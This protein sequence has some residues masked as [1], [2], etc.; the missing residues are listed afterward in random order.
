MSKYFADN[1]LIEDIEM[2]VFRHRNEMR[3]S[4]SLAPRYFACGGNAISA[5][6]CGE[7]RFYIREACSLFVSAA[8]SSSLMTRQ[9]ETP[10]WWRFTY[11]TGDIE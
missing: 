2:A 4:A 9:H 3:D 5:P 1:L 8:L 7:A 11:F 6:P 10:L